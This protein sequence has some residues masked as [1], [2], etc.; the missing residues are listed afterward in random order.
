MKK[1]LI[2][3]CVLLAGCSTTKSLPSP[4]PAA[5]ES[6]IFVDP[7]LL[8][9]CELLPTLVANNYQQV[10]EHY[11]TIIGLYGQ[12]ALKQAG[13]VN[14]IRKLSNLNSTP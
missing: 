12:C 9:Q 11:L 3:A 5:V 8:E 13:S 1:L 4:A 7:K 10:A 6:K 2:I 14:T